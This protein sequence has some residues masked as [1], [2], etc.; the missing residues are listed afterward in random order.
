MTGHEI[1]KRGIQSLL[2]WNSIVVDLVSEE[3]SIQL[4][5]LLE[6]MDIVANKNRVWKSK[7]KH[8]QS[9]VD[10]APQ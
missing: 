7:L 1:V 4:A 10:S 6:Y 5:I 2:F 3:Y 8:N 9:V